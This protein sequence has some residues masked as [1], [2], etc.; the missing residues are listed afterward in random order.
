MTIV[1]VGY[2]RPNPV[3]KWAVNSL[4]AIVGGAL[5]ALLWGALAAMDDPPSFSCTTD[6]VVV[7]PGDTLDSIARTNCTGDVNGAIRLLVDF[8]GTD[9]R[10]GQRIALPPDR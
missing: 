1:T 9:I 7:Q 6:S 10:P 4:F 8:Y 2:S 3:V 5:I